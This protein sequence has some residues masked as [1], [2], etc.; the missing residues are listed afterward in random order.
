MQLI[1]KLVFPVSCL[2]A[3]VVRLRNFLY[4]KQYLA[5]KSFVTPTICV[6]NLSL[7]GTGKTPMVEYLISILDNSYSLA[8]LSRGYKRKSNGFVLADAKGTVAQLGDEAYMIH[9]KYPGVTVAVDADRQHGIVTLEQMVRPDLILLDDAFQHRKVRAG[10]NILLTAYSK[11]YVDDWCLPTGSLRDN[12]R[13]A[14]RADLIVV[15]KCPSSLSKSEMADIRSKLKPGPHQ[16]VVFATLAYGIELQGTTK[17]LTL[18][19]LKDKKISLV[20]GIADPTP[21]LE[22][23]KNEAISFEHMRY[24]DHHSFSKKELE[25]LNAREVIL[26]TE[27]DYVRLVDT[28][29]NL[30]TIGVKHEFLGS[31]SEIMEREILGFMKRDS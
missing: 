6:G 7:G 28:V 9:T 4:D 29:N 25:G 3:L 2:Y 10:L 22:H 8:V 15:T 17:G 16:T 30:Y 20:T 21:L 14:R 31:G 24:G 18:D 26:T 23:L 19:D 11:L 12:R 27:K 13:E 1:R 5:S